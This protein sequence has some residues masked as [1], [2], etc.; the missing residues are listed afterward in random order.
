M[1]SPNVSNG[2]WSGKDGWEVS[3]NVTSFVN[4]DATIFICESDLAYGIGRMLKVLNEIKN[5]NSKISVVRSENE[6]EKYI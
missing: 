5:P 2:K 6:M 1:S 4:I 3:S